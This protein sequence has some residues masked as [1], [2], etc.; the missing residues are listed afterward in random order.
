MYTIQHSHRYIILLQL[1]NAP[2]FLKVKVHAPSYKGSGNI[3]PSE[4]RS[5]KQ[6]RAAQAYA[7]VGANAVQHMS[8]QRSHVHLK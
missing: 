2:D 8:Q 5:N 7:K 1:R 6:D 4:D 3:E